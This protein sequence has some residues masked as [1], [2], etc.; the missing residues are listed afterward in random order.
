MSDKTTVLEVINKIVDYKN[1]KLTIKCYDTR[2]QGLIKQIKEFSGVNLADNL[3]GEFMADSLLENIKYRQE[4]IDNTLNAFEF[5]I[6]SLGYTVPGNSFVTIPASVILPG[7]PI[8]YDLLEKIVDNEKDFYNRM[9]IIKQ[10][11]LDNNI[12]FQVPSTKVFNIIL[13]NV[14]EKEMSYNISKL[15][16]YGSMRN[17]QYILSNMPVD[18]VFNQTEVDWNNTIYSDYSNFKNFTEVDRFNYKNELG[19]LLKKEVFKVE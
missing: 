14:F 16:Y 15:N 7:E 10:I 8:D 9:Q 11:E 6:A 3:D 2:Y 12:K 19:N 4:Q 17:H 5:Y 13:N 1:H 18:L